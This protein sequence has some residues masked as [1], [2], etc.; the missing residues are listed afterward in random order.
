MSMVLSPLFCAPKLLKSFLIPKHSTHAL[1]PQAWAALQSCMHASVQ[2]SSHAGDAVQHAGTLLS[3]KA[4]AMGD[5]EGEATH[6]LCGPREGWEGGRVHQA[7]ACS[8]RHS[9]CVRTPRGPGGA[10]AMGQQS[11]V[12]GPQTA[13]GQGLHLGSRQAGLLRKSLCPCRMGLEADPWETV[14]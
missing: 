12:G 14:G 8:P 10:G 5:T 1:Q 3:W 11:Q 2:A 6:S 9:M 7:Q 4:P 13:R